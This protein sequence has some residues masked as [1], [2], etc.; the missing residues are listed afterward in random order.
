[1]STKT[2]RRG[3]WLAPLAALCLSLSTG[4]AGA[5]G[6]LGSPGKPGAPVE[7]RWL[8]TGVGG[9][10]SVEVTTGVDYDSL[11]LRLLGSALT[12]PVASVTLDAGTAGATRR[13]DWYLA[14]DPSVAPRVLVILETA[15][16][17]MGRVIAAPSQDGKTVGPVAAQAPM[18]TP[19]AEG[20]IE[21]RGETSLRHKVQDG[22]QSD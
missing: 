7:L 18:P 11:E 13:A 3:A 17:R 8:E 4:L 20:L 14:D 6:P 9:R 1:M 16:Q 10:I 21:M 19:T 5:G 22:D 15:G 2:N 12:G